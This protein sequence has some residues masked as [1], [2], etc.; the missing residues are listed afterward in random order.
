MMDHPVILEYFKE[1][2]I[3]YYGSEKNIF[4]HV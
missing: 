4:K 3:S 1:L 2:L